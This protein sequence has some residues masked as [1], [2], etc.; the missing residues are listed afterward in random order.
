MTSRD[1]IIDFNGRFMITEYIDN[2]RLYSASD[3][4]ITRKLFK[5]RYDNFDKHKTNS[6]LLN[7]LNNKKW[8]YIQILNS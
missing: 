7:K 6:K 3:N 8:N 5:M 2:D 4:L 1:V